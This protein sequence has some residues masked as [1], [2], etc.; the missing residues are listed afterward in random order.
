[1]NRL[2]IAALALLSTLAPAHADFS[3]AESLGV[4]GGRVIGG[5]KACDVD[6]TRLRATTEKL[7]AVVNVRSKTKNEASSATLLFT[8]AYNQGVDQ[9]RRRDYTCRDA[10]AA[11]AE[12]E[13][14]FAK[15]MPPYRDC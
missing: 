13:R 9:I 2:T 11:F 6:G 3:N 12:I 5:A 15:C 1:M 10:R 8:T 4:L 14:R 7:F